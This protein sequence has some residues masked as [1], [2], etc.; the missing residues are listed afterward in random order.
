MW[1]TDLLNRKERKM[2][3]VVDEV[4]EP[5]RTH[6]V[7]GDDSIA[8]ARL[9]AAGYHASL[10]EIQDTIGN[11]V[12]VDTEI[13]AILQVPQRLVGNTAEPDLQCRAVFDDGGDV[14]RDA[15]RGFARPRM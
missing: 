11:D 13:A 4:V 5:A 15:L 7:A 6:A 1:I 2:R 3:I 9:I 12:A 8:V 10:H 14:A